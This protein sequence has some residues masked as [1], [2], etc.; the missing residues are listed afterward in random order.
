[1]EIENILWAGGIA[2]GIGLFF[3][4]WFWLRSK[5]RRD[6]PNQYPNKYTQEVNNGDRND[7]I[8]N[9]NDAKPSNL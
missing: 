7:N 4:F 2:M 6:Y 9:T 1:M 3:Q 8:S 5:M